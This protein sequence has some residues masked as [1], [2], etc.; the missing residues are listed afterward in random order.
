MVVARVVEMVGS[1]AIELV[2]AMADLMA[3][4][5]A[6]KSAATMAVATVE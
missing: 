1:M 5:R 4:T 2:V 6:E 3:R